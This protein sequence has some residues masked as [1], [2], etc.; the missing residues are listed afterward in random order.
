MTEPTLSQAQAD[1][2]HAY[3]DGAPGIFASGSVWLVAGGVAA[4]ATAS[5]AVWTLLIGGVLIHPL[6]VVLCKLLGRSGAHQAGNPLARLAGEGTLWMLTAIAIAYGMHVLRIEWFFPAM[7]LIIGG[8]Y[9]SFQTLFGLRVY[10]VF[11]AVLCVA[12]LVLALLRAPVA[13]SAL[14]GAA[15]ELAFA[16]IVFAHARAKTQLPGEFK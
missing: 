13:V 8:R 9:L 14:A 1:M 3:L 12:G 15:I 2:R 10:W 6:G 4:Y 5:Q 7:L 16:G 11:G